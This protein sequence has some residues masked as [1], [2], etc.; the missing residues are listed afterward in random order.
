MPERLIV[1]SH[2]GTVEFI[3]AFTGDWEI[4]VLEGYAKASD[5]RGRVVYGNLPTRLQ[6]FC[7]EY[8][9]VEFPSGHPAVAPGDE[10]F[11]FDELVRWGATLS[12]YRVERL[13]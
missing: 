13:T 7:D 2:P 5:L 1:S 4:P 9:Q 8:W 10:G 3:R 6:V 12:G 11:S